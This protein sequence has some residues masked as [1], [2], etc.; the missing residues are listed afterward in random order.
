MAS[1]SIGVS[2]ASNTKRVVEGISVAGATVV[3]PDATVV[4]AVVEATAVGAVVVGVI[5][6]G[7]VVEATAVGAVVV[8][9]IVVGAVVEATVVV[10]V[11]VEA[12]AVEVVTTGRATGSGVSEPQEAATAKSR[13]TAKDVRG[14]LTSR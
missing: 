2:G 10:A 12:T 9:V 11:V 5:V 13:A 8:G 1:R 7:A 6:V 14:L 4:G 3:A